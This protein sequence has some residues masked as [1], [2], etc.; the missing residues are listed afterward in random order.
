M[1]GMTKRLTS[2]STSSESFAGTNEETSTNTTAD[3]NHI[4][5]RPVNFVR[6]PDWKL[7]KMSIL[8][9]GVSSSAAEASESRSHVQDLRAPDREQLVLRLSRELA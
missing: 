4:L 1:S 5:Q 8:P 3:S 6:I 9:G 2:R 7:Y